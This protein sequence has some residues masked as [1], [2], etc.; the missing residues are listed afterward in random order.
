MNKG[1][2]KLLAALLAV[3]MV[4]AELVTPA[5]ALEKAQGVTKVVSTETKAYETNRPEANTNSGETAADVEYE[6][7]SG[8]MNIVGE[9]LANA[10]NSIEEDPERTR[11]LLESYP[12]EEHEPEYY[13]DSLRIRYLADGEDEPN[14]LVYRDTFL[15]IPEEETAGYTVTYSEDGLTAFVAPAIPA[16]ELIGR[17]GIVFL[18]ENIGCDEVLVFSGEPGLDGDALIVPLKSADEIVMTELFSDGQLAYSGD[19]SQTPGNQGVSV[20]FETNP[21]GTNWEGEITSFEPS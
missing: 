15:M 13:E 4:L 20:D 7:V 5:L 8:T 10:F 9:V 12:T 16:E 1:G 11:S 21:S 3:I 2:S 6:A 19:G 14:Y 17:T 18:H